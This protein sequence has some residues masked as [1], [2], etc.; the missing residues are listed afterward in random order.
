MQ[1]NLYATSD[2]S[3]AATL[4]HLKFQLITLRRSGVKAEFVFEDSSRLR[5]AEEK[6]WQDSLMVPAQSFAGSI[7]R[8]KHILYDYRP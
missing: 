5:E 4:L 1:S 2:L 3:L 8:A 7:R 6:Y